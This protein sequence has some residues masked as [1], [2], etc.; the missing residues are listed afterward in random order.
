MQIAIAQEAK[1]QIETF[2]KQREEYLRKAKILKHELELLRSEKREI[3]T[4][5][6]ST[7]ENLRILRENA[8]VQ[9]DIQ[10][11]LKSIN[12]VIEILSGT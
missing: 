6:P 1:K 8:K 7:H 4:G 12:N 10:T 9:A 11:N 2:A 3:L 5:D